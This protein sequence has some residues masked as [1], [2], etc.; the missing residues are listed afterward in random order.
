[1][2]EKVSVSERER[3]REKVS[4]RERGERLVLALNGVRTAE[5]VVRVC[6]QE[7]AR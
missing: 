7:S 3:E 2:R 5:N 4:E 1:M 6:V